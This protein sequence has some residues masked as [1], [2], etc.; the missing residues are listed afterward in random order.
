MVDRALH[1]INWSCGKRTLRTIF[2]WYITC[3]FSE[4]FTLK[5]YF[6]CEGIAQHPEI[7][8]R[9]Y[10]I[11]YIAYMMNRLY[12]FVTHHHHQH[13]A[14]IIVCMTRCYV[15]DCWLCAL[16]VWMPFIEHVYCFSIVCIVVLFI[17]FTLKHI[18]SMFYSTVLCV[19]KRWKICVQRRP[20]H[21]I[22]AKKFPIRVYVCVC[23]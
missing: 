18:G 10:A 22:C 7:D 20:M 4:K 6:I 19:L 1:R 12:D 13:F 14:T 9:R 3:I 23:V 21:T 15:L 8:I 16:C 17:R 5:R 2:A 11:S